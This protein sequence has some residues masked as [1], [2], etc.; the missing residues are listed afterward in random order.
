MK[1]GRN[2]GLWSDSG[3]LVSLVLLDAFRGSQIRC[4][5]RGGVSKGS[6]TAYWSRGPRRTCTGGHGNDLRLW[7]RVSSHGNVRWSPNNIQRRSYTGLR[8]R[9]H[10][11]EGIRY[12]LIS[13]DECLCYRPDVRAA[14]ASPVPNDGSPTA[15]NGT[16]QRL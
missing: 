5:S 4:T 9:V 11:M 15:T 12:L 16:N 2:A 13:A 3:G 14:P 10:S 8:M 1:L 7:K 6:T